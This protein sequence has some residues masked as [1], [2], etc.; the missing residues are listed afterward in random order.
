MKRHTLILAIG[1]S[2]L[3]IFV[4]PLFMFQVRTTEVA[5]VTTFGHFSRVAGPGPHFRWGPAQSVYKFDQ[6]IHTYDSKLEQVFTSDGQNALIQVYV[7][8]NISDAE[9]FLKRFS[10]DPEKGLEKAQDNLEGLIRNAYSGVVGN[11]PF[12]HFVS[13]D[14]K[15]LKFVQI[16]QEMQSRIQ[17]DCRSQ[18]NGLNI[19]FLGIKRIG[20]PES[21]TKEVF[22]R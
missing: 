11:H 3:I 2:L 13:T 9:T 22:A 18:T 1:T 21:A 12:S 5:V 19:A 8:W 20:L 16:E 6:R 14:E 7:G 17:A 10:S 15:Q 4:L